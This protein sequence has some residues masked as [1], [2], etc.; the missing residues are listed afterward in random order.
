MF[1]NEVSD[2][3]EFLATKIH[4]IEEIL[5]HITLRVFSRLNASTTFICELNSQNLVESLGV[6]GL[7]K[8]LEDKYPNLYSFNEPLPVPDAMRKRKV[9][10]INTLPKWPDE[11]PGLKDAPDVKG[12]RTFICFPI[13]KSGTPVGAF[14]LF[15]N[16]KINYDSDTEIFLKAIGNVLALHLYREP[17]ISD[18]KNKFDS[19]LKATKSNS[20]PVNIE[21]SERQNLIL[22]LISEGRTNIVIGEL[23]GYSESTVRQET[24]KIFAKLKCNGREEASTIYRE[25]QKPVLTE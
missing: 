4:T 11:Y 18:E 20:V 1:L 23:L 5:S 15:C 13:E 9:L 7:G 14:G 21:L 10:W 19:N 24:I 6:F 8:G 2:F 17:R 3:C 12:A 22:R 16:T 25:L